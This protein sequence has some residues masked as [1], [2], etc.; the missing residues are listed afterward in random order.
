MIDKPKQQTPNRESLLSKL[1]E[2]IKSPRAQ[3]AAA[4]GASILTLAIASK[5]LLPNSIGYL[6]LAFPPFLAVI[7]E[8]VYT[9]HPGSKVCTTWYWI[10]AIV[11]ATALVIALHML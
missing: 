1:T 2:Q 6:P 5:W 7:F 4:A 10:L 8:A 9:K 3:I 11:L